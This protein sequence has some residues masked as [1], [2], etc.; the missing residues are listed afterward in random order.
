MF[1]SIQLL[2]AI[3]P[4][5]GVAAA[6]PVN[7]QVVDMDG[8]RNVAVMVTFGTIVTGAVTSIKMQQSAVVEFSNPED[9]AGSAVTVADDDD[10]KV[11][12]IEVE[13]PTKRFLRVVVG[14]GTQNAA[15]S[16][17]YVLSNGR[18]RP[19]TA[20]SGSVVFLRSPAVA[21]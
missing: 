15:V 8:Y 1:E 16:A 12:I 3:D 4:T 13:R 14:R 9:L 5:A 19:A 21:A 17:I 7:G 18:K 11:Y 6:T 2:R 10:N 20:P